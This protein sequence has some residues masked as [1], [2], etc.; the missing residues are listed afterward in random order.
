MRV[1]VAVYR[2]FA[3]GGG[4][5]YAPELA[6]AGGADRLDALFDGLLKEPRSV[7]LMLP[8]GPGEGRWLVRMRRDAESLDPRARPGETFV[9]RVAQL[10]R[11]PTDAGQ[12][13]LGCAL[14][15]WTPTRR[16]ETPGLALEVSKDDLERRNWG[17]GAFVL[18][19]LLAFLLS[20]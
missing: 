15:Q 1:P 11:P 7:A 6:A 9:L 19:L 8:D 17:C 20:S 2:W 10:P 13:R 14:E 18:V 5:A 12:E 16:G 4:W 3:D